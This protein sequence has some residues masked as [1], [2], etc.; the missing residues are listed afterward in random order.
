[1][2]E[3]KLMMEAF[4]ETHGTKEEW[5]NDGKQTWHNALASFKYGWEACKERL[6]TMRAL[7][8]ATCALDHDMLALEGH[9]TCPN[10]GA[11]PPRM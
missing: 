1:M 9:S 2:E 7:D 8:G 4:I 3:S 5:Y 10:C 6:L 11:I